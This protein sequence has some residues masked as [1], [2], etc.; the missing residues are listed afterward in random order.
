MDVSR[1][2]KQPEIHHVFKEGPKNPPI[3][4]T[5]AFLAATLAALPIL[6]ITVSGYTTLTTDRYLDTDSLVALPGYQP[7]PPSLR[8]EIGSSAA[9]CLPGIVGLHRGRLLPVLHLLEHLPAAPGCCPGWCRRFYQWQSRVGRSPGST[10]GRSP[11]TVTLFMD[12]VQ[13]RVRDDTRYLL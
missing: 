13:Y 6:A 3:A 11:V 9:R 7:Q 1:Y 2:G 12:S 8:I 10:T 5:L 4:I